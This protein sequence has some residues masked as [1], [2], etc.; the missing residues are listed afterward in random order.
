MWNQSRHLRR[1]AGVLA[2]AAA[3]F[4]VFPETSVGA[5]YKMKLGII[6]TDDPLHAYIKKYKERI[7]SLTDG[8]IEAELYPGGQLGGESD[9]VEGVQLGT[10]EMIVVPP[11]YLSG[12]DDRVRVVDA[13]GLFEDLPHAYRTVQDPEFRDPFLALTEDEGVKGISLWVYDMTSFAAIE[14]IDGLSDVEGRKMRILASEVERALIT[15][16]GATGV[17]MPFVEVVPSLERGV[18]DGVRTS[19]IIMAAFKVPRVAPHMLRTDDGTI[20]IGAYVSQSFFDQLPEDLQADVVQAGEDVEA[21]MQA[22]VEGAR[23]WAFSTWEELGGE[24][25]MASDEERARLLEINRTVSK[26]ILGEDAQSAELYDLFV[27]V[28]E[29]HRE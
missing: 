9:L 25:R 12:I 15:E 4:M 20:A 22:V 2:I 10:V 8:R 13:P 7:E 28:A 1:I 29:R 5:E 3:A 6:A 19:P 17:A 11:V 27:K 23:E 24:I 16:L 21:E 14:P 18:I 26:R